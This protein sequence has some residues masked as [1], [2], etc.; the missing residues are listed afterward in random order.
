VFFLYPA[1]Q[2]GLSGF[3]PYN[4]GKYFTGPSGCFDNRCG[5][6]GKFWKNAA[7]WLRNISI[8]VESTYVCRLREWVDK[9]VTAT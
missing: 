8:K 2:L 5:P 3:N 1:C 6:K 9:R 7:I 4:F